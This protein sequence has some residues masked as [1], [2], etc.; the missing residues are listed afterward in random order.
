MYNAALSLP[1]VS[2]HAYSACAISGDG[3]VIALGSTVA[4]GGNGHV[5][6]Y[7]RNTVTNLW[8]ARGTLVV[9]PG[10]I[11]IVNDNFKHD[12]GYSLALDHTG[13]V[14]AVGAPC[15][16]TG[17]E[18]ERPGY[19]YIFQKTNLNST[20]WELKGSRISGQGNNHHFG[21]SVKLSTDGDTL[22]VGT[23]S[24]ANYTRVYTFNA[25]NWSQ[26]GGD[27]VLASSGSIS[28]SADGNIVA[29][30]ALLVTEGVV[31]GGQVVSWSWN[32]VD[33]W[34]Q[35]GAQPLSLTGNLTAGASIAISGGANPRLSIGIPADHIVGTLVW[36]TEVAGGRWDELGG[37]PLRGEYNS[38]N[39][40]FGASVSIS[41]DG[42]RLAVGAPESAIAGKPGYVAVYSIAENIGNGAPWRKMGHDILGTNA[43]YGFGSLVQLAGNGMA[44]IALERFDNSHTGETFAA[45]YWLPQITEWT[46]NLNVLPRFTGHGL[47][48][49]CFLAETVL[50]TDQGPIRIGE[51]WAAPDKNMYSFGG[52]RVRAV[53]CTY[54]S[55]P[56]IVAIKPGALGR[57]IPSSPVY[58]TPN[59]AILIR[60]QRVPARALCGLPGVELRTFDN[61]SVPV[62]NV[63]LR[64]NAGGEMSAA[65]IPVESL[66]E[67]NPVAQRLIEDEDAANAEEE[68]LFEQLPSG[69]HL[70]AV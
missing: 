34:I 69:N 55:V 56:D 52:A 18:D 4:E 32:N 65:G 3:N 30:L 64:D 62:F 48:D 21:S 1:P 42:S 27:L 60:G 5:V 43:D 16:A 70:V 67:H 54:R 24:N 35:L 19:A 6:L 57:N 23:S 15:I 44:V 26:K 40:N 10:D 20:S 39:D 17:L 53:S 11:D 31:T 33:S 22:A 12:F 36:N 28:M 2:N 63:L 66:C 50:N 58:I 46:Q 37:A 25:T 8:D 41:A 68:E 13:S 45:F 7:K 61:A 29:A 14:I 38:A 47:S 59:H 49:V 51:L 9:P